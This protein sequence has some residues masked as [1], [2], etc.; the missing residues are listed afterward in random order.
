MPTSFTDIN[1]ASSVCDQLEN[2]FGF[3]YTNKKY[4]LRGTSI[5]KEKSGVLAWLKKDVPPMKDNLN[6]R[7][8]DAESMQNCKDPPDSL[9]SST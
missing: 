4:W 3:V 5:V 9:F 2:C 7:G 1:E 8:P 6:Y